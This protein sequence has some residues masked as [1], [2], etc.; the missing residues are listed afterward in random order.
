V[1]ANDYAQLSTQARQLAAKAKP[2]DGN[3]YA[4]ALEKA[5]VY[6]HLAATALKDIAE[7][8]AEEEANS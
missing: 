2:E 4:H 1:K 8:L 3:P 7:Y 6:L 5:A